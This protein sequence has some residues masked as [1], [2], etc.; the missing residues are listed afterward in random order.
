M[1]FAARQVNLK[2]Y[3]AGLLMLPAM[4]L[5]DRAVQAQDHTDES[6]LIHFGD[7]IDVD[8]VGSLEFDWRGKLS[9]EGVLDGYDKIPDSVPAVCRSESDVA[10]E[11]AEHLKRILRE[12]NVIVRIIDRTGRAT[13]ILDGAV[14]TPQRFQLRRSVRLNELIALSGGITDRSSGEIRVFRPENLSCIGKIEASLL[15]P[16]PEGSGPQ[17]RI[18]KI[19]ELIKGIPGTNPEIVSGDIVSV[20]DA[21]PIYVIGG[22]AHHRSSSLRGP[23]S[24]LPER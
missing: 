15:T 1:F 9:P 8:V 12:P 3:I 11:I 13:A 18:I 6:D 24:R 7:L 10:S 20:L 23:R 14:R 22:V 4:F 2:R 21:F 19:P 5:C 16:R 17:T